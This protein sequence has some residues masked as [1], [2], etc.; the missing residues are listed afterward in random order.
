[1]AAFLCLVI[2]HRYSVTKGAL[3]KCSLLWIVA[4]VVAL[5]RVELFY[6]TMTQVSAGLGIGAVLG[7]LWFALYLLLAI[8]F[9]FPFVEELPLGKVLRLRDESQ[10]Y[11]MGVSIGER[12]YDLSRKLR[13][14]KAIPRG[15]M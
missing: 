9:L 2:L 12:E 6:H 14:K 4:A 1:M 8:P 13:G 10:L 5:G 11:S 15:R 3:A 7:V